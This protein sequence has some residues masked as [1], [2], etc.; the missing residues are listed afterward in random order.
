MITK[1]IFENIYQ[2]AI[3]RYI[4]Y[5]IPNDKVVKTKLSLKIWI[6]YQNNAERNCF[7]ENT[8]HHLY[9]NH[10]NR[11]FYKHYKHSCI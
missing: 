9:L 8:I 7:G 11:N 5:I 1:H 2:G 4:Y 3:F 10:F 6:N